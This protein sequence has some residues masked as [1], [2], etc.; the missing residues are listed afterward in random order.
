M[1]GAKNKGYSAEMPSISRIASGAFVGLAVLLVLCGPARAQPLKPQNLHVIQIDS[2]DADDQAEA[3]T[4]ALR[5]RARAAAGWTLLESTQA[6]GILTAALRCPKRPDAACLQRVGDQIKSDRFVWGFLSKAGG[7]QVTADLHLWTRGKPDVALKETYNDNLKDENED[8]LRKIANRIFDR[9]TGG[10]AGTLVVHAGSAGG[11]VTLDGDR[12]ETLVRGVATL[13]VFGGPHVIEVHAPGFVIATE[14]VVVQPGSTANVNVALTP[15]ASSPPPVEGTA[16]KTR[17]T[18]RILGWTGV[19][20]GS[21]LVAGGA[22]LAIVFEVS[23]NTLNNDRQNNYRNSTQGAII[24]D[25]CFPPPGESNSATSSGCNAR[26][27]AQGVLIPEI[28]AFSAGGAFLVTGIT[29]LSTDPKHE[30]PN[31]ASILSLKQLKLSP[32]FGTRGASVSL[33]ASF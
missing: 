11:N 23:R 26:S 20:G 4:A 19:V 30:E 33:S 31:D 24:D 27:L 8:A 22:A 15:E 18:Q 12:K 29:L 2:N 32:H 10:A 13:L 21:I 28:V 6:I 16:P 7:H 9:L 14:N 5:S 25:P 17:T 1:I 3:L